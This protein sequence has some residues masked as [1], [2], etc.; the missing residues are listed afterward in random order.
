[1]YISIRYCLTFSKWLQLTIIKPL[2]GPGVAGVFPFAEAQSEAQNGLVQF[3]TDFEVDARR[4]WT[5]VGS[6]FRINCQG[7]QMLLE[8][9]REKNRYGNVYPIEP[10]CRC[11]S[12]K[13]IPRT[14]NSC[15]LILFIYMELMMD[16]CQNNGQISTELQRKTREGSVDEIL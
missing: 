6:L 4:G 3:L 13:S 11:L 8:K 2:E 16:L 12:I 7:Q 15:F 10:Q 5:G 14:F 9:I 1:M